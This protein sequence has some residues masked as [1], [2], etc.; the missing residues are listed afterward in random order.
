M[1]NPIPANHSTLFSVKN[2]VRLNSQCCLQ[3]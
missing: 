2:Y 3:K 1:L